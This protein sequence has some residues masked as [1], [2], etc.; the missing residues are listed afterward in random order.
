MAKP[1][2]LTLTAAIV[3][4]SAYWFLARGGDDD[5]A[6]VDDAQHLPKEMILDMFTELSKQMP[7]KMAAL[8]QQLEVIQ[9]Y[10]ASTHKH[11]HSSFLRIVLL[12][13]APPA[14]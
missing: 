13:L 12:I 14:K 1:A 3:L 11:Y 2:V 4:W 5:E 10:L 6:E 7:A 8:M 9:P